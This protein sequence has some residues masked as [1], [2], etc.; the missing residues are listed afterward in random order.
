MGLPSPCDITYVPVLLREV[1]DRII[2]RPPH[3]PVSLHV[4]SRVREE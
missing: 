4:L 2:I 1:P 3:N